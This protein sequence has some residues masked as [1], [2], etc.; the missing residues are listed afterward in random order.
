VAV[1]FETVCRFYYFV[2]GEILFEFMLKNYILFL[3]FHKS[4][5]PGDISSIWSDN[6]GLYD[7]GH[8]LLNSLYI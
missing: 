2:H 5:D 8:R 7:G 3:K 4:R 1:I 6:C